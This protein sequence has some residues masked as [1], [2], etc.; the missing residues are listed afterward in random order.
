MAVG[1]WVQHGAAASSAELG[2]QGRHLI[3]SD[4]RNLPRH[5]QGHVHTYVVNVG[6]GWACAGFAPRTHVACDLTNLCVRVQPE[7]DATPALRA[8]EHLN[9]QMMR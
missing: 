7:V 6:R 1:W 2:P 4:V 8:W 9:G 5:A 3:S